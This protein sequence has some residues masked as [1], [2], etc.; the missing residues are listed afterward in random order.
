MTSPTQPAAEFGGWKLGQLPAGWEQ[1]P[2][3]GLRLGLSS[4]GFQ[5]EPL[6]P[7]MS[8]QQY[9]EVQIQIMSNIAAGVQPNGP[10]RSNWQGAE[11]AL[12][13]GWRLNEGDRHFIVVQI[14]AKALGQVGIA[15][16]ATTDAEFS[17]ASV[18]FR[19][20]R[21]Q[22][23]FQPDPLPKPEAAAE[24]PGVQPAGTPQP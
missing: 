10:H 7:E 17:N 14:L 24:Q 23:V 9:A 1:V 2:G 5:Q 4:V 20:V 15:T 21:E 6:S 12:D 18:A 22:L 11:E 3:F 13:M 16:F 19:A 8:L